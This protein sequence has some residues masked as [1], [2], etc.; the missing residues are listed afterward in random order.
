MKLSMTYRVRTKG[1]NHIFNETVRLYRRRFFLRGCMQEL[2]KQVSHL[3]NDSCA[4]SRISGVFFL[5]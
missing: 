4:D 3:F 2:R 5:Q 1:F